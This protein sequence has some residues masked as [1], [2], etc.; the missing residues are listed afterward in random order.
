MEILFSET[1][2]LSE[3][4]QQN[5][6]VVFEFSTRIIGILASIVAYPCDTLD[7]IQFLKHYVIVWELE[8]TD[9]L[10]MNVLKGH[11]YLSHDRY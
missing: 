6:G 5:F 1:E 7:R 11:E 4:C 8:M 2:S 10:G 3:T 9:P